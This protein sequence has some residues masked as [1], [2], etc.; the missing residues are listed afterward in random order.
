MQIEG[1]R[2]A[3]ETMLQERGVYKKLGVDTSTVANWKTYLREGKSISLDKMEEMLMRSGAQVKQE[4]VWDIALTE[5]QVVLNHEADFFAELAKVESGDYIEA[6]FT[7][8]ISVK[9]IFSAVFNHAEKIGCL[10]SSTSKDKS[11]VTYHFEKRKAK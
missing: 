8:G 9:R 4:K 7:K 3:F 2:K 10:L 5:N 1:T 11:K 6:D